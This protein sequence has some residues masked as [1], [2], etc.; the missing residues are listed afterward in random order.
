VILL[1]VILSWCVSAGDAAALQRTA[2][3]PIAS[4]VAVEHISAARAAGMQFDVDPDLVLAISAHEGR[5]QH[6]VVTR[7][8]D[9]LVSCGAMTPEPVASCRPQ[10]VLEDYLAGAGHL[11]TWI[12]ATR[13]LRTALLGYAGGYAL[14]GACAKGPVLRNAGHHDDLCLTPNVFLWRRDWIRRERSR[15]GAS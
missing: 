2:P 9:G 5:Y 12:N 6:G 8:H 4:E 15:A 3:E 13:D 1:R 10:T 11:R 14:I 7:E